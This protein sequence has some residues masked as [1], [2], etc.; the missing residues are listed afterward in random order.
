MTGAMADQLRRELTAI[1]DQAGP[2]ADAARA[3][4]DDAPAGTRLEAAILALAGHRGP[5]SSTCPSDAA[6]AVGGEQWRALMDDARDTARALARAGL[7]EI[8]QRGEVLDPDADW[9]GPIRIRA[10]D[11]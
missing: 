10:V 11:R 4:L 9:R 7:V 1:A 6:R 3:A 2:F 8:T 5:R